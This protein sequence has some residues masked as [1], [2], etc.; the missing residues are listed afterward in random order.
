MFR[1]VFILC[2]NTTFLAWGIAQS[3]SPTSPEQNELEVEFSIEGGFYDEVVDLELF[4]QGAR[5]YYTT[6]GSL[7]TRKRG[8]R[9]RGKPIIVEKTTPIRAVAYRGKEKSKYFG[10][11]Y[12]INEPKTTIPVVSIQITPSLLFDPE[13]GL[14]ME[15]PDVVD[16]IWSKPGANFWS[17]R[18]KLINT[19]IFESNKECVF[20]SATGF[21]LFG[22][23][24]RLFPQKSMVLV[25]RD[26]YGEKRIK[27]RLFGKDGLKKFKFLVLRN[28]GSDFGKTHF[29]DGMMTSLLEDW[30]IEKQDYRPA[31]VYIN[32]EYW[33]IYNIREKINRYFLEDHCDVDKDSVD[34]MEHRRN[35]KRGS[36]KHYFKMLDYIEETDLFE[37]ANY[38]YLNTQMDIQNFMDYKIA[39]IYFDNQDA[40]GNIKYWRP[41]T[42]DGR[43]RWIIYDT[44]WG[45]GLHDAEAYK[46]NSIDF[47]TEEDGPAWPNPPWSTVILRKLMENPTFKEEFIIRTSDFINTTFEPQRVIKRINEY[48]RRLEPEIERHL[49]RWQLSEKLWR[50][51]VDIMRA[52][53]VNRPEYM[54]TYLNEILNLGA[55]IDVRINVKGGG[56]VLLNDNIAIRDQ[57]FKGIYFKNLPIRLEAKANLGYRFSHWEGIDIEDQAF[58]LSLDESFY[59]LKAV[60]VPY[61][62]PLSDKVVINEINANY[63][64]AGDWVEI[65]NTSNET[66]SMKQWILADKNNQFVLPNV[67]LQPNN[68]VIFAQNERKFKQVFPEQFRVIGD[69]GFGFNKHRETIQLFT[70]KGEMIDSI[71]YDI[72]PLDSAFTLNLLLPELDNADIEN[73]DLSFGHG[74]P[75]S[76]NPYYLESR[77]RIKQ[78]MWVVRGSLLGAVLVLGLLLIMRRS[79]RKKREY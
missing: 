25:T 12:F 63:K 67:V 76:A 62:H 46:N 40:G 48:Q 66:I 75:N 39:Q 37:P 24:S 27:H 28:S 61:K 33:G 14:F 58:T 2:L 51:E 19:E 41:R 43:W 8:L 31:Q 34:I 53:A 50:R 55:E 22:G 10:H 78:D 18:E 64:K 59:K 1:F 6:D 54:R 16:S 65:F 32:G 26:D 20:R 60:F 71:G 49:Q 38:A 70:E 7:P 52:F 9:Y 72:E 35:R 21:R 17:K 30:D 68:Y 13:S 77:V 57:E 74:T 23:M 5:I 79:G 69:L 42:E 3:S 44:D 11:T 56:Q 45:M 4:A 73:W 15:G 29:R 47:H 36:R